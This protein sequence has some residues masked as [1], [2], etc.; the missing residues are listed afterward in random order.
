MRVD[1]D[2]D[3]PDVNRLAES[4]QD[5]IRSTPGL[6]FCTVSVT[7]S[8][9]DGLTF[10]VVFTGGA[11]G[12]RAVE[13]MQIVTD[14]LGP[15]VTDLTVARQIRGSPINRIAPVVGIATIAPVGVPFDHPLRGGPKDLGVLRPTEGFPVWVRRITPK[16]SLKKILDDF[17]LRLSGTFP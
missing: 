9:P 14:G 15:G 11:A 10:T 17:Q 4:L 3:H 8:V 12:R 6:T 16:N 1:Y 7:G 5:Q 2:P 13:L